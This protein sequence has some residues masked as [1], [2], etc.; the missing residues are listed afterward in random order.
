MVERYGT[1]LTV[2]LLVMLLSQ[3]HAAAQSC[4]VHAGCSWY[5]WD[6]GCWPP[7]PPGAQNC[8]GTGP[9]TMVCDVPTYHCAPP[10]APEK[11]CLACA[12]NAGGHPINLATGNT[13]IVQTDLNVPGLGGGLG[14]TRTW[15]SKW[16]STQTTSGSGTSSGPGSSGGAGVGSG[17]SQS[18]GQD[19]STTGFFGRYWRSNYEEAISVAGNGY[20]SYARGDGSVWTFGFS[21]RLSDPSSE[22]LPAAPA[23]GDATLVNDPTYWTLTYKNGEKRVFSTISGSLLF[24]VDRNGNTTQLA[25]DAANRLITVTDPALRHLNFSYA[26]SPSLSYLVTSVNT[27][28]GISLSYRYDDTGKLV[29]ITKPDQTTL[30]FEYDSHSLISAV[31]DSEGKVL[32]SHTYDSQGRGL[33]SSRANGVDAITVSYPKPDPPIKVD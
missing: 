19:P 23:N 16:P 8:V 25:Y 2:V 9:W 22:Y 33:T 26:D 14:L 15:N 13:Y 17:G 20:I 30:S 24:I 11:A 29:G 6:S 12:S 4:T 10:D 18:A 5:S 3:P 32:E 7:P 27:D 21:R 28:V 31:K 1:C